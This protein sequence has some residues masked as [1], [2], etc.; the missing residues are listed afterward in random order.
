MDK[1]YSLLGSIWGSPYPGKLPYTF[2]QRRS[3]RCP[4]LMCREG[5]VE[6]LRFWGGVV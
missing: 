2:M 4:F 3:S 5:G 6:S 1:N